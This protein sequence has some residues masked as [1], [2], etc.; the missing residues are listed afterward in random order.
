MD[1]K[2]LLKKY[3]FIGVVAIALLV[4]VGIYAADAYK[5][6]DIVVNNK[7]IDGKYVAYELDGQ[8]VYADDLYE[9]LYEA[10]G[11][12]QAVVAFERAIFEAGYETT[13]EMKTYAANSAAS[14]LSRYSEDY[15]LGS[16]NSMGYT[17]GIDDLIPYYIDAQKQE[18][19]IKDYVTANADT[20]LTETKGTNG[21]LIYHILVKTETQPILDEDENIIG[22]EALPTD[23]QKEKLTQIQDALA[24][25]N[26]TFEYVA[27]LH[28]DDSSKSN[29]GYIGILN[30]ENREMYDQ[31]FADAALSLA[32]GEVSEP[33]V[34]Q[35][36]YH[37][38]KNVGSSNE[39][40]LND[41]YF[42]ADLENNNPTLI[43]KAV[44]EKAKE[45]G[46][47]IKDEGLKAQIEAQLEEN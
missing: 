33:V 19:L 32:D 14:I 15:V 2:E 8:P 13:E 1:K 10:G 42:I 4:F 35:F 17:G 36:G 44:T 16:L 40:L 28:S 27:Y 43:I 34:S 12:S 46:F 38:I 24:D 31:F 26:N 3:W 29:G 39:T 20:Y 25:E 23:E 18:L 11:L 7:Q 47:E 22:Y 37:I 30:E 21:R 45:L 6:R 5:N 9:S 41:Y